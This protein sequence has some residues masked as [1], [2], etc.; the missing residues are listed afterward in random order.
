MKIYIHMGYPKSASSYLQD[1]VFNKLDDFYFLGKPLSVSISKIF[2]EISLLSNNDYDLKKTELIELF[3]NDIKTINKSKL[4][5][6]DEAILNCLSFHTKNNPNNFEIYRTIKRLNDFFMIFGEVKFLFLIRRHK[7]ILKS[8]I[9]HFCTDM[10]FNFEEED[11]LKILSNNQS[12]FSFI[13]ESFNY[14][15]L[16][17]YMKDISNQTKLIFFEDLV[18]DKETFFTELSDFLDNNNQLNYG[19]FET[20]KVNYKI[21][22]KNYFYNVWWYLRRLNMPTLHNLNKYKFDLNKYFEEIDH[23]KK[24]FL[25]SKIKKININNYEKLIEKYYLE[26]LNKLP[27]NIKIKCKRYNYF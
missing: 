12:K 6:S 19:D 8:Y 26:D 15:D 13:L 18:N 25:P 24:I 2:R 7:D 27:E 17:N 20:E 9:T 4:I 3:K 23:I 22:K 14:G 11:F 16:N 21:T 5:I 10:K 1:K